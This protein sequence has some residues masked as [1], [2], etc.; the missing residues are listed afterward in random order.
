MI[1]EEINADQLLYEA[2]AV[3]ANAS[4]GNWKKESADWA[5][6]AMQWRDRY[7][8]LLGRQRQP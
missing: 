4:G 6:A 2:W 5:R 8:I 1:E 3:I 7:H